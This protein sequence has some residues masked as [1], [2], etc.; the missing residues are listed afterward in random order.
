MS[1]YTLQYKLLKFE[2]EIWDENKN[3]I[4]YANLYWRHIGQHL[5][6]FIDNTMFLNVNIENER[7]ELVLQLKDTSRFLAFRRTWTGIIYGQPDAC[8]NLTL[9]P[10]MKIG[11]FMELQINDKLIFVQDRTIG[12]EPIFLDSDNNVLAKCRDNFAGKVTL[13]IT[14]PDLNVYLVAAIAYL[15]RQW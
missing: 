14:D 5:A 9:L 15:I 2:Q 8:F 13:N 11:F 6:R 7:R 3:I 10:K 12:T 4:G 1:N